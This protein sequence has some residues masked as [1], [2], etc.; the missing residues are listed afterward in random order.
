MKFHVRLE[1]VRQEKALT[2]NIK[3]I[4]RILILDIRILEALKQHGG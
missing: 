4:I 3:D 1:L 2:L